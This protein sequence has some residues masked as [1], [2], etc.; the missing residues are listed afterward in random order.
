M[1]LYQFYLINKFKIFDYIQL[2]RDL[3]F[4]DLEKINFEKFNQS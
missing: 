2:E 1:L 4:I 3:I